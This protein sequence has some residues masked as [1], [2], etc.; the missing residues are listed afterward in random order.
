[1]RRPARKLTPG[2][3]ALFFFEPPRALGPC[4]PWFS[5]LEEPP[6][7]SKAERF[8]RLRGRSDLPALSRAYPLIEG[9]QEI[10]GVLLT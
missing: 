8:N 2:A 7:S 1:M 5:S 4:N 9:G 10:L 3:A 6:G